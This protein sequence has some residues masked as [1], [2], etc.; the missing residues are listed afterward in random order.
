MQHHVQHN[1]NKIQCPTK[2]NQ[3]FLSTFAQWLMLYIYIYIYI[4]N[5]KEKN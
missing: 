2:K 5:F 1:Y 3:N 4:Y